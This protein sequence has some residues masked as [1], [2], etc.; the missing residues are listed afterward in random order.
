MHE[1]VPK[2]VKNCKFINRYAHFVDASLQL[3]L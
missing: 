3:G 2:S 1:E